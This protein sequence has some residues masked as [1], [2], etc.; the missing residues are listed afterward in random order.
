MFIKQMICSTQTHRER[1]MRVA[2]ADKVYY[3]IITEVVGWLVN[4]ISI[5]CKPVSIGRGDVRDR[6][7][8][9]PC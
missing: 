7:R 9:C 3:I 6:E 4:D 1:E 5:I 2:I 8:G